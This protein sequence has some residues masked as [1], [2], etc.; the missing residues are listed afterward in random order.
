MLR[1]VDLA[2]AAEDLDLDMSTGE[3]LDLPAF[4]RD[5]YV[6]HGRARSHRIQRVMDVR[7]APAFS[8]LI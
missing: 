2:V 5:D 4:A 3:D 1:A 7:G 8:S 6:E